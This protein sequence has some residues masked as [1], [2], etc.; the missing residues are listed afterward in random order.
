MY[1]RSNHGE[2]D[3][4]P[5]FSKRPHC[6]DRFIWNDETFHVDRMLSQNTDFG[7]RGRMADNMQPAHAAYA[8]QK[9]SWGVGRY[10]FTVHTTADRV[11]EIY[12]D[13]APKNVDNRS[14]NWFLRLERDV[15]RDR[16]SLLW[17][18]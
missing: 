8:Q 12:Y 6:P 4:P 1:R 15:G 18:S 11:F 13:R 9:G 17:L 7:R 5:L 10:V 16:D 2:F 14:G 3:K